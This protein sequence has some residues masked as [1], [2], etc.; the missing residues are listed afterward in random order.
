[1]DAEKID[2]VLNLVGELILAKSMLQ[3]ALLEFGS[4]SQKMICGESSPMPWRFRD[5]S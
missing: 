2:S 4:A 5:G 1:V 3:Q